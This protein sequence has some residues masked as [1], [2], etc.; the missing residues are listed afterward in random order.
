MNGSGKFLDNPLGWSFR[1]GRLFDIDI[2]VHIAFV[3]CAV[4]LV[5][6][7]MPKEGDNPSFS[8]GAALVTALGTYAI[9]F[10]IVLVHEFGHCFGARKSGG[11]AD[12]ILL[13]P[14]GGL[15]YTSPAPSPRSH[16]ITV[17]AGPMVNVIL[18]V[19]LGL[20]LMLW[21]GSFGAVPW[22][23]FSVLPADQALW[24][25]LTTTRIW[26]L[27]FFSISYIILLFNLLPIFP[28]DGGRILQVAL[29]PRLGYVR[30]MEIATGVGIFGAIGLGLFGL[31]TGQSWLLLML[32]V[33]GGFTCWQTRQQ[34]AWGDPMAGLGGSEFAAS[35][36]DEPERPPGY[37]ERRNAQRAEQ[38]AIRAQIE[39]D[40]RQAAVDAVLRKVSQ[41]GIGSLTPQE[42]RVL[43][44]ETRR[45]QSEKQEADTASHT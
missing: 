14:L 34:L 44:A 31:F 3:A 37:F 2:R 13:W 29:W 12:Q 9:M 7:Q 15:A 28:F 5:W 36:R 41:A 40:Q 43:E 18:C 19:L 42:R 16:M 27:R 4:I 38:K 17:V 33:F 8:I 32:A 1:V 11:D 25:T 24:P 20:L 45:R 10:F 22:N 6:M 23:P 39:E 35:L 26:V 21:L 30:S